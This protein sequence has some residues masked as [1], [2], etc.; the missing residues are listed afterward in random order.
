MFALFEDL[1][2]FDVSKFVSWHTVNSNVSIR[3][4]LII[5]M[6][7]RKDLNTAVGIVRV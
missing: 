6:S 3:V 7:G 1:N 4:E 5:A 2:C